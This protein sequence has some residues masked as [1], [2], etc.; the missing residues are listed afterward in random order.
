MPN[1]FILKMA[2]VLFNYAKVED[3]LQLDERGF[4][5]FGTHLKIKQSWKEGGRGGTSDDLGFGASVYVNM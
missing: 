3:A 2:L 4:D 5:F 1:N